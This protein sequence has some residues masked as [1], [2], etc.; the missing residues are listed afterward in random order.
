MKYVP[1]SDAEIR[2]LAQDLYQGRIFTDRHIKKG[3]EERAL[4]V[5]MPL[6]FLKPKDVQDLK[7]NNI[8]LFYEYLS[9]AGPRSVNGYPTFASFN[10]LS[11]DDAKRLFETYE[12]IKAAVENVIGAE[13]KEERR[14]S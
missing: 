13:K 6:A 5:F 1:K 3:D 7:K 2:E 10:A 14:K 9:E 11:Q 12:K 8:G 4:T